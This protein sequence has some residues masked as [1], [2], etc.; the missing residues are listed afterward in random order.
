[1][2]VDSIRNWRT[3]RALVPYF[4]EAMEFAFQNLERE[5]GRYDC[6]SLP[7]GQVYISVQEGE[8]AAYEDGLIEAHRRYLDVQLLL[9]GGETFYYADIDGLKEEVPYDEEKDILFY[10]RTGQP[11]RI[12]EGMFY[13][14]FPQDGHMPCRHLDGPGRY[15]KMVVK[16]RI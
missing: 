13:L 2:I 8:T 3:Y 10:E 16:I 15:R 6:E 12:K 7:E 14:V 9:A 4:E 11:V 5:P 1:M